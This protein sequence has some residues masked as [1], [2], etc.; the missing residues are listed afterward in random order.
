MLAKGSKSDVAFAR[1]TEADT[2]S[3][4]YAG[5][6]KHLFEEFPAWC[7]VWRLHPEIRCILAA[8]DTETEA[9]KLC[10]HVVGVLHI[11]GDGG[12]HLL[13]ALGGVDGFGCALTD[14]AGTIELGALATVP[15]GVECY[16]LAT[17]R[18]GLQFFGHD[19]VTASH[20]REACRLG[21][22]VE[23]YRHLAG[24]SD[25]V[26]GV[27]YLGIGD[28]GLVGCVVEDDALVLDGIVHP[29]AK[30]VLGDDGA[31]GI[32]GITEVDHVYTVVGNLG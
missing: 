18:L 8:V 26:D 6:I 32:V 29:L 15:D 1:W 19:G 7:I 9:L 12:L 14:V 13:L 30:L 10:P 23:L 4:D 25:L 22:T 11:V 24:A 28:V 27:W 31:G 21:I 5:T 16:F 3:A 20:T 2:W 17:Q